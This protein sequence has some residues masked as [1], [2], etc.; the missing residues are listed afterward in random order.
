LFRQELL[1]T[2]NKVVY[3]IEPMALYKGIK[4]ESK[5]KAAKAPKPIKI[6]G[7]SRDETLLV[8]PSKFF[9]IP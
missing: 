7:S 6:I 9:S 8:T 1:L 4:V 3:C 5:I 2:G